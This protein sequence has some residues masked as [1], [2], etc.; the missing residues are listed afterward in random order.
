MGEAVQ[1]GR[2]AIF[3]T[4]IVS[5]DWRELSFVEWI[6]NLLTLSKGLLD[7][8]ALHASLLLQGLCITLRILRS[9]YSI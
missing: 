1:L 9:H 5:G 8:N 3:E 6:T 2:S 4:L 7:K